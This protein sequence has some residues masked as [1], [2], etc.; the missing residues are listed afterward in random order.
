MDFRDDKGVTL[1]EMLVVTLLMGIVLAI[2]YLG[3][4][5]GYRATAVAETQSQFARNVTAPLTVMDASFSQ[6]VPMAGFTMDPYTATVRLP[7]DY[8]PGTIEEHTFSANTDGTLTQQIYRITGTTRTLVRT[9]TWSRENAN[10]AANVPLFT[11]FNGSVAATN[12]ALVNNVVIRVATRRDGQTF[13]DA[14]RVFF[15]N[16]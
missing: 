6:R 9:V 16:R 12:A 13:S 3:I 14:R 5:F 1:T 15:R 8:R 7:A 4:Q 10:R 11:Y 2:V